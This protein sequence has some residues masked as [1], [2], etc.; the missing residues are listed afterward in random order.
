[1]TS[2]LKVYT[3]WVNISAWTLGRSDLDKEWGGGEGGGEMTKVRKSKGTNGNRFKKV[4]F[5][6]GRGNGVKAFM[7]SKL[8]FAA[9]NESECSSV[10]RL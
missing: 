9:E 3:Q 6:L 4:W 7:K 8:F 1:M 10:A 2:R 5:G